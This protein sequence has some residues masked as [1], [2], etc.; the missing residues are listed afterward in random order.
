MFG[1]S[2]LVRRRGTWRSREFRGCRRFL[3][4]T[5]S[6]LFSGSTSL[7]LYSYRCDH[8]IAQVFYLCK[9]REQLIACE[10]RALS[11]Y[12]P[13]AHV[14]TQ[15][16]L[17]LAPSVSCSS[18]GD[19]RAA[20]QICAAG[21]RGGACLPHDWLGRAPFVEP[22]GHVANPSGVGSYASATAHQRG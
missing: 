12:W 8:S 4:G 22:A 17:L 18:P 5:Y 6:C 9:W 11:V 2:Q 1:R 16:E 21:G 3:S 14:G 7:I 20:A 10:S 13:G 19:R 15:S